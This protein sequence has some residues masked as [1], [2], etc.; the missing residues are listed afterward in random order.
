MTRCDWYQKVPNSEIA[1]KIEV[2]TLLDIER[3]TDTWW[4]ET[5]PPYQRCQYATLHIKRDFVDMNKLRILR[6]G[7]Y[8]GLSGWAQRDCKCPYWREGGE[9]E[10][11][12]EM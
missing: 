8:P 3:K 11:E 5:W 10:S 2:S 4:T 1:M 12:K 9:S 7:D 6:W